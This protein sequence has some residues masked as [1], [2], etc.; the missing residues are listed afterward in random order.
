[1]S[2]NSSAPPS[3][4]LNEIPF[5][6]EAGTDGSNAGGL[7]AVLKQ[8]QGARVAV[9]TP[10]RTAQGAI[11]T[12]EERKSQLDA[13][14]PPLVTHA[15]VIASHPGEFA[16]FDLADVRSI[17]LL[18]DV[19]R[20]DITEFANVSASARRRDAKTI[21]VTSEGEGSREMVVSYTIAAPIWKTTYRVVLDPEGKPFFQGWAVV[22]NVS[23]ED[24]EDV[25]LSLVSGTPV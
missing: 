5:A 11:L 3:A 25:S 1:V 19:A 24:W 23:E 18:D 6:I 22:D 12:V 9:T 17:R 20:K 7:S 2:Y 4:R 21:S 10:T 8:F 13:N 15:L 16:S 14:K